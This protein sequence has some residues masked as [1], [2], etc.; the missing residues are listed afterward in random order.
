MLQKRDCLFKIF[1]NILGVIARENK[2]MEN[3]LCVELR[4]AGFGVDRTPI[5]QRMT[6]EE[7]RHPIYPCKVLFRSTPGILL[8]I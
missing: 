7:E 4:K 6:K 1:G 2:K 5:N 8:L 3:G